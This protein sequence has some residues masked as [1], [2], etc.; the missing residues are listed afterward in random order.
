MV[1]AA[2]A[3]EGPDGPR[4]A[5]DQCR[6][7][8]IR[9]DKEKGLPCSNCQAAQ[10]D[11]ST[12]GLGQKPREVRQRVMISNQY[13]RKIDH[14]AARLTGIE[15]K[16]GKITTYLSR[17]DVSDPTPTQ[18]FSHPVATVSSNVF[19]PSP[20]DTSNDGAFE[21]SSS[22]KAQAMS[23]GEF[24][25]QA[26]TSTPL[27]QPS[28]DIQH[29]L[30]SLKQMVQMQDRKGISQEAMF[31]H[32]KTVPTGGINH[33][34][35]P[36]SDVVL[37]LLR[38]IQTTPPMAFITSC[39]FIT[40]EYFI[41]S[42]RNVYFATEDY[43]IAVFII[44]NAG[45]Y[46]LFQD[47][48]IADT[49]QNGDFLK[50]HHLCRDNLETA[51]SNWPL[52]QH[53]N[54]EMVEALL[55]G[56]TYAIEISKFTLGYQL[57]SAAAAMCQ[58]LGWHR[59]E[60]AETDANNTKLSIFWFCYMMDKG[61]S[62][63]FGRNSVIQDWDVSTP[64]RFGNIHLTAPWQEMLNAWIKTG[65][66]LGDVYEQLYSPAAMTRLAEQQV[67]TAQLLV[68]TMKQ[69]WKVLE[70]VSSTVRQENG[71]MESVDMGEGQPQQRRA[72][73]MDM[74]LKS[75]QVTHLSSLTLIYRA[76]P[77]APGFPSTFNAECI[78]A[79]RMAFKC[80]GECMKL[81]SDSRYS[82]LGYLHWTILYAPFTPFTVL[83]CHVIETS[84]AGDLERLDQFAASLQPVSS[85]SP[86][87]AKFQRLCRV[88]H[89]IASLYVEAKSRA[90]QDHDMI[91]IG[92]DFDVYFSQLGFIPELHPTDR[93]VPSGDFATGNVPPHP[94][95]RLLEDWFTGNK[96]IMGM[97]EE[98]F[99]DF[100]PSE[101][102]SITESSR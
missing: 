81:T 72:M 87:I 71:M 8:K 77:S 25:E 46:Y 59:L 24:L 63:R 4:R 1:E 66:V 28:P 91:M 15:D 32:Q 54:K 49:S 23:V 16:L 80:H 50:Y 76:I 38:E 52:L 86:A 78:D 34:P 7:R 101:W 97:M 68:Q 64:R 30:A 61:L 26:V 93:V 22:M 70:D 53:S 37:K 56:A 44:V 98:D 89:Q 27:Q 60:D 58:T 17:S 69:Q 90:Q 2:P 62:L 51:L 43:N 20:S 74:I 84:N 57:N 35:M 9:C 96:S 19:K 13:E 45:L 85:M 75:G 100:D 5:C 6:S 40:V 41:E 36:P 95:P 29:A 73:S 10:R 33:L 39:S 67:D 14:L 48:A 83:F 79:A 102:S 94:T 92:N 47:K 42:C 11:C 21:G 55:L 31:A 88:L 82:T 3:P 99:L 12:T 18:A 65:S